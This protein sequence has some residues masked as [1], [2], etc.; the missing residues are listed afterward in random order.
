MKVE[1]I[2]QATRREI[3]D[4]FHRLRFYPSDWNIHLSKAQHVRLNGL[5]LE[6]ELKRGHAFVV[7][8]E[9]GICGLYVMESLP[10]NSEYFG[11]SCARIARFHAP[12][13][14]VAHLLAERITQDIQ[15]QKYE[16]VHIGVDAREGHALRAFQQS[17]WHVLWTNLKMVCDA[18]QVDASEF[19]YRQ[20]DLEVI[21]FAAH[22]LEALLEIAQ[23]LSGFTWIQSDESLPADKRKDYAIT[24]TRNSCLTDYSDVNLTLLKDGQA[25]G[26]NSSKLFSYPGDFLGARYTFERNTFIDP[27]MQSSGY[28][29]FLERAVVKTL[30]TQ[31]DFL[32]GKVRL[33]TPAMLRILENAGFESQGGELILVKN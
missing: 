10:W 20:D 3:Q 18:A 15:K 4:F 6:A 2:H 7:R 28:G 27:A 24:L 13:R 21:P 29:R 14:Q 22:H 25:I 17:D 31:V 32:T 12:D 11:L 33:G 9:K 5:L 23:R 8:S 19:S 16:H 26:H 30:K 1:T